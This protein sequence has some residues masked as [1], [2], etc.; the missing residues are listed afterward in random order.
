MT[1]RPMKPI[2]KPGEVRKD[3]SM[4]QMN[5]ILRKDIRYPQ[6]YKDLKGK[7]VNHLKTTRLVE[8]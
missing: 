5:N 8:E 6:D 3:K 4:F 2:T 7:K 1:L